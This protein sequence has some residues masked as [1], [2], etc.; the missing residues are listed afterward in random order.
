MKVEED[1][2]FIKFLGSF[3]YAENHFVIFENIT[4]SVVTK[5]MFFVPLVKQFIKLYFGRKHFVENSMRL[6]CNIFSLK[7]S[8]Y[9]HRIK[10]SSFCGFLGSTYRLF[11]P[12]ATVE[13]TNHHILLKHFSTGVNPSNFRSK[14]SSFNL[15]VALPPMIH[16]SRPNTRTVTGMIT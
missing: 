1:F 11:T 5:N 8:V 7:S 14:R 13:Q 2:S 4:N 9:I 16:D 6:L 15:A 12:F 10:K 3:F